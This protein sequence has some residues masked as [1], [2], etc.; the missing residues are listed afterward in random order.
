[1]RLAVDSCK[2]IPLFLSLVLDSNLFG[3]TE[4]RRLFGIF[5]CQGITL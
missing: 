5:G 2:Y 3:L 4:A 1:M